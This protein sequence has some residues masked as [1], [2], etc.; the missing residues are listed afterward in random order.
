V[1]ADTVFIFVRPA[2]GP[3]MP[4][5]VIRKQVRE[6]PAAFS[7]D[8]TMAM[9]TGMKLSAHPRLIVGARISKSGNAVPQ[10]G[11]LEGLSA[12]VKVGDAGVTVVIST[13]NR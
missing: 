1:P 3:R 5:A 7:L 12:P 10:P 4:L 11:D 8:D 13:E 9:S 2:D 6:L